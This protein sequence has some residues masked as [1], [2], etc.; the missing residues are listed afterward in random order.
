MCEL[1]QLQEKFPKQNDG[2]YDVDEVKIQDIME[3][4]SRLTSNSAM[5]VTLIHDESGRE[6]FNTLKDSAIKYILKDK[7]LKYKIESLKINIQWSSRRRIV[8]WCWLEM[9]TYKITIEKFNKFLKSIEE[10]KLFA[11]ADF[12]R[13]A[14][15]IKDNRL[16]SDQDIELSSEDMDIDLFAE[17]ED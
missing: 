10:S 5:E 15:K 17:E 2:Q 14:H 1:K 16:L 3:N 8:H 7:F 12:N 11:E 4:L 9:A 6:K 13:I